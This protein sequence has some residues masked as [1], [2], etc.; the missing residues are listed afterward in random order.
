MKMKGEKKMF[1]Q[2]AIFYEK[3]NLERVKKAFNICSRVKYV[4]Y[5]LFG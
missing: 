2:S 5:L 1:H 4:F 3:A